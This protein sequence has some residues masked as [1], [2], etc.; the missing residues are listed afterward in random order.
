MNTPPAKPDNS[1]QHKSLARVRSQSTVGSRKNKPRFEIYPD[2]PQ[3]QQERPRS[4]STPETPTEAFIQTLMGSGINVQY[5]TIRQ[6]SVNSL[7]ST[8][9]FTRPTYPAPLRLQRKRANSHL[10]RTASGATEG[11]TSSSRDAGIRQVA[12]KTS[13]VSR[14]TVGTYEEPPGLHQAIADAHRASSNWADEVEDVVPELDQ[15]GLW[16]SRGD[17]Q[18]P[19]FSDS[20]PTTGQSSKS[21][22]PGSFYQFLNDSKTAWAR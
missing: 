8:T 13:I 17:Y 5:P 9:S 14:S 18:R 19:S 15:G 7:R 3:S 4:A 22:R 2:T 10:G 1:L 6:P 12:S 11:W 21:G 16:R 20:R